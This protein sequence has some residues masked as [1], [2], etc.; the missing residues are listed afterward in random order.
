MI[1]ESELELILS[2][3]FYIL[4]IGTILYIWKKLSDAGYA[5]P[6]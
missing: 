5:L 6:Y 3:I 4:A 2:I 1:T